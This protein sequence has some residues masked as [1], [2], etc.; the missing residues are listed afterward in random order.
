MG[1]LKDF[2]H[3]N[4]VEPYLFKMTRNFVERIHCLSY[5]EANDISARYPALAPGLGL[6]GR[7]RALNGRK[8]TKLELHMALSR[9]WGSGFLISVV[10]PVSARSTCNGLHLVELC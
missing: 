3:F 4:K 6:S 8:W 2:N 9:G 10:A 7:V 5:P 1:M